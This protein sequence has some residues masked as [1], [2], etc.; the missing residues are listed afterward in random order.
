MALHA[1]LC[2]LCFL[3]PLPTQHRNTQ[4]TQATDTHK[5]CSKEALWP[6]LR[7]FADN[8]LAHVGSTL[9]ALAGAGEICELYAV[10]GARRAPRAARMSACAPRAGCRMGCQMLAAALA[11]CRTPRAAQCAVPYCNLHAS[12]APKAPPDPARR[13]RHLQATTPTRARLRRSSLPPWAPTWSSPATR[14]GATSWTTC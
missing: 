10:H 8:A 5:P 6:Y 9:G 7:E 12:H 4:N 13:P 14:W 2:R 11:A 1:L 3:S